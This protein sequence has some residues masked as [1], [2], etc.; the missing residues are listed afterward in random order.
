M[1]QL[2]PM[3][4]LAGGIPITLLLDLA[5][6]EH[7]SS[8]RICRRER[9]SAAWLTGYVGYVPANQ[10]SRRSTTPSRSAQGQRSTASTPK[11]SKAS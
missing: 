11:A 5:D 10:S 1:A 9:G 8:R 3:D 4:L 2:H 6:A 7:F